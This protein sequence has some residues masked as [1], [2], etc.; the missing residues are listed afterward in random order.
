MRLITN[1]GEIQV[2]DVIIYKYWG[3]SH[4]GIVVKNSQNN[5]HEGCLDV[6]HYG[7]DS[8]FAKRTITEE[9]QSFNLR[10]QTV[11]VMSFDGITFEAN[12]VVKRARSRLGEKRHHMIHN[13]SLQFVEWAKTGKHLQW[14]R[15]TAYGKLQLHYVYGWCD[16]EKGSIV[17]FTYYGINHQGIL[18]EFDEDQR[19]ISVIH[20]GT[21]GLFSTRTIIEDKLDMDL[22]T[23]TLKM[24]QCVDGMCHNEPSE[25][26]RKAKTR[27]GEQ[28]WRAGN[29]SWDFCLQCLFDTNQNEDL[30][31][32]NIYCKG[33]IDQKVEKKVCKICFDDSHDVDCVF[34]D[35]G[36]ASCMEC[37]GRLDKCH[38]CRKVIKDRM[39]VY[40]DS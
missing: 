35:C 25:V 2:G 19:T 27:L 18:T 9:S 28:K 39:K 1:I 32:N 26:I 17:E 30:L 14:T 33:S 5:E 11:H 12:A 22:K 40:I 3:L 6:I 34:I 37:A 10:T 15:H 36:H 29:R 38:L 23:Q 13:K 21:G 31:G 7:A 24:Y 16:L 8:L 4:E 20:Y